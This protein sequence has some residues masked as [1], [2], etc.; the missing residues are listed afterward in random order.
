MK[1]Q[2]LGLMLDEAIKEI[3]KERELIFTLDKHIELEENNECD[4]EAIED[5]K[6]RMA[7]ALQ[8]VQNL[9]QIYENTE[10]LLK[11]KMEF[12]EIWI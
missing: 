2:T 1:F 9:Q 12:E 4:H 7:E 11:R 3:E 8:N 6:K 10:T 5:M